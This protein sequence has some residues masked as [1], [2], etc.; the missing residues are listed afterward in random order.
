MYSQCIN[1]SP[2]GVSASRHIRHSDA[3]SGDASPPRGATTCRS[4]VSSRLHIA[5]TDSRTAPSSSDWS[6]KVVQTRIR[7]ES[8][9]M[10]FGRHDAAVCL[11]L[12]LVRA[13]GVPPPRSP[14]R[15]ASGTWSWRLPASYGT[16]K[17][18]HQNHGDADARCVG[19]R[20]LCLRLLQSNPAQLL[21]SRRGKESN[22]SAHTS[23]TSVPGPWSVV[24]YA[25]RLFRLIGRQRTAELR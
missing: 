11:P 25:V 15:A 21:L 19:V 24:W 16:R 22:H 2:L 7:C 5:P 3:W 9:S 8:S 20:A 18:Q 14:A 4:Q 13:S 12:P 17:Q 1:V 10:H 23:S 6:C